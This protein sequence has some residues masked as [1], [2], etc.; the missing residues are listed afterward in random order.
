[1]P[2]DGSSVPVGIV[3]LKDLSRREL[4]DLFDWA[5]LVVGVGVEPSQLGG[6]AVVLLTGTGRDVQL[7]RTCSHTH[8][9]H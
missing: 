3:W 8:D 6:E 9:Q 7:Q 2:P 4:K 1:M 5:I